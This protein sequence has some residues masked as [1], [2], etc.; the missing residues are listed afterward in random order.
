[1]KFNYSYE[2]KKFD[3][4][5]EKLEI[6]YRQAGMTEKAIMEIRNFD[7]NLFKLRRTEALHTQEF[8]EENNAQEN[9]DGSHEIM[10]LH[11]FS[12]KFLTVEDDLDYHSRY[13]WIEELDTPHLIAKIKSLSVEELE[14]LDLKVFRGLSLKEIANFKGIPYRTIKYKFAKIKKL[15]K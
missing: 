5:W 12:D 6:E 14:I 1:M 2:K 7:W 8:L 15:L 3:T 9:G 11:K 13:W 10:L 4:E